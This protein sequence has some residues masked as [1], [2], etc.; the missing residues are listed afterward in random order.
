MLKSGDK[1]EFVF[2]G[3]TE[4]IL[5]RLPKRVDEVFGVLHLAGQV[6]ISVEEMNRKIAVRMKPS[7]DNGSEPI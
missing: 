5:R 2:I 6:P 3:K 7:D 4:A 1:I